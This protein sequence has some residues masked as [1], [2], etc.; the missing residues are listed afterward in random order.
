M[1]VVTFDYGE[2]LVC[3]LTNEPALEFG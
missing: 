2:N 1:G 3:E